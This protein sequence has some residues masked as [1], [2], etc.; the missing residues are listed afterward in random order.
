M[1][2]T[3]RQHKNMG[4]HKNFEMEKFKEN[5]EKT[6]IK[7]KKSQKYRNLQKCSV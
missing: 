2:T 4:I 3:G 7:F 6:S 1:S 5:M